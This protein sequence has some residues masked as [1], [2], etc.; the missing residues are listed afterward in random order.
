[1]NVWARILR[2]PTATP[3]PDRNDEYALYQV[4][5]APSYALRTLL[6]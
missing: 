6:R 4:L 2:G 1:M 3:E 5:L